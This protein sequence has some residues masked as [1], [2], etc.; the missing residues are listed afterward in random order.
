MYAICRHKPYHAS[1]I[2]GMYAITY[3]LLLLY[4]VL[5]DLFF[6]YAILKKLHTYL[7]EPIAYAK[8]AYMIAYICLHNAYII[9]SF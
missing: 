4:T 8:I 6:V 5:S 7:Q 3:I 2:E 1:L 9:P